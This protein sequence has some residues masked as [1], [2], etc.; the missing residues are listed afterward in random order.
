MEALI[1]AGRKRSKFNFMTIEIDNNL[2]KTK[3][4]FLR[5]SFPLNEITS[6]TEINKRMKG[7]N[8]TWKE[9]TVYTPKTKYTINSMHWDNYEELKAILSNGVQRDTKKEEKIYKSFW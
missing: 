7:N 1:I 9:F 5:K 6:W 8:M 4:M 2:V 3:N